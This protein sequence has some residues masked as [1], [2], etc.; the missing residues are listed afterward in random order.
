MMSR[1]HDS[2]RWQRAQ[3]ILEAVLD[4]DA[5]ERPEI[6]ARECRGDDTLRRQVEGYLRAEDAMGDFIDKPIFAW[7]RPAPEGPTDRH[8]GAYRLVREIGR[9]GM[10]TVHLAERCDE[11]FD[12]S[13][14]I[15]IVR[16]GM[17]SE[18][19]VGRF[20]KE[21]QILAQLEHANIARLLD[22]GTTDSGLPYFVMEH[23]EGEPIDAYC[24]R[25]RLTIRD[26][27]E[28]FRT[29][30]SAVHVAHQNLV[31]HRDLKPTNILVTTDGAPKL[32]D[33]GVAKILR[34]AGDT[35]LTRTV[36]L[37]RM[38]PD[39]ASPEQARNQPI[40]TASDV[41]A[42][43]VLLY[44]L[45]TGRQ[46]YDLEG[47]ES[48]ELVRVIAEVEPMRPSV[49]V[50]H[51]W[52]SF[53]D[54]AD[55]SHQD[56]G[57]YGR[58]HHPKTL[59]RLLSGDLDNIVLRALAKEPRRR[60]GSVAELSEDIRRH[61]EK[62]PV[63]ARKPTLSYRATKFLRRNTWQVSAAM[64]VLVLIVGFTTML[65]FQLQRT[66]DERDRA[67]QLLDFSV[68]LA[69]SLDPVKSDLDKLTKEE[70]LTR[71]AE[72]VD[73]GLPEQPE[74]RALI[75]D[76]TGRVYRSLG[77]YVEAEAKLE[78]ALEIRRRILGPDATPVAESLH[79]LAFL[80]RRSGDDEAAEPLLRE[81][82]EIQRRRHGAGD[83]SMIKGLNNLAALLRAQGQTDEALT[84]YRELLDARLG[85]HGEVHIDVAT[86]R[87]N[88]AVLLIEKN[89]LA[90]AEPLLREA[91]RLR[92]ELLGPKHPKVAKTTGILAVLLERMGKFQEAEPWHRQ[93]LDLQREA[94]GGRHP[95]VAG[96]LNNLAYCLQAAGKLEEAEPLY[97]EAL[98]VFRER[99]GDD[100]PNVAVARRNLASLLVA[101]GVA[102]EAEEQARQ[103]LETWSRLK[104][105]VP[106]RV[107][108]ARS[109]LGQCLTFQGRFEEA[110]PLLTASYPTIRDEKGADSRYTHDAADRIVELYQAWGRPEKASEYVSLP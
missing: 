5:T 61:L 21:R 23:V 11:T 40:T 52:S 109:V 29:V 39:Y 80:L 12:K 32:L 4:F 63:Q 35:D 101:R 107:A 18:E 1:Q 26:R 66:A 102:S 17:D 31:V 83:P 33:F 9:G 75:L 89:Q 54:S 106:W 62:L 47:R 73:A 2:A 49:A 60:Y 95:E 87:H 42:L 58:D 8:V 59:L 51:G 14:A 94:F 37:P 64:M 90:E 43:G 77:L 30:C 7:R 24:D 50:A 91:L 36:E 99:F 74:D 67:E 10:G 100:H 96:A 55:R 38:T 68:D 108:D 6:L 97:R 98:D 104:K 48:W 45:L 65:Y 76:R 85:R 79:N 103:A 41:Y 34:P 28:L 84:L 27:L 15:K 82:L 13:V 72:V 110:E 71:M 105:P 93:R 56:A 53:N 3:E 81:A 70:I 88:L 69:E 46:P 78:E 19:I 44:R 20:H 92:R 25:R 86:S 57:R 16:R 22:G